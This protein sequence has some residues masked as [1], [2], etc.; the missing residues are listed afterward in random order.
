MNTYSSG[1]FAEFLARQYMRLRGYRILESRYITGRHTG[2]A[3][4]DIIA[5]RGNT[6]V[7]IE[8]KNRPSAAAGVEAVTYGQSRR[9]RSA[10]ETYLTRKRWTGDARFDIIVVSGWRIK[11]FRN[12]V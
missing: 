7:F 6:I 8:V 9:L 2:R 11:H 1:L 3:E 10:A 4:I 12:A 5:A